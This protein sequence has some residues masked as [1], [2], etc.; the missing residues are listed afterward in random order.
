MPQSIQ[1]HSWFN[2]FQ[3]ASPFL[4][5]FAVPSFTPL[6]QSIKPFLVDFLFAR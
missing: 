5:L 1:D 6:T 4:D 3:L 2:P